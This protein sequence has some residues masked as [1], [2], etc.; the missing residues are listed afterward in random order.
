MAV[1][2]CPEAPVAAPDQDAREALD[3]RLAPR[4]RVIGHDD[5]ITT[6]EFVVEVLRSVFGLS[7]ARAYERMMRIHTAGAAV[8]GT[9]GEDEA[10]KRVERATSKARAQGFPLTFTL[11]RED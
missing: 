10:R 6:M 11:E 2:T 7:Q 3:T 1:P 5:P 8:I 9:W 4:W